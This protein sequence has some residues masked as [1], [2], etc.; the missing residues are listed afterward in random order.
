MAPR[1]SIGTPEWRPIVSDCLAP[2]HATRLPHTAASILERVSSIGTDGHDGGRPPLWRRRRYAL[3]AAAVAGLAGIAVGT[4][5]L[6]AGDSGANSGQGTAASGATVTVFNAEV[7][8]QHSSRD[9]C[10]LGLAGDP[11]APYAPANI[12]GHVH[13]GDRLRAECYVANA[14]NVTAEDH[15]ASRRWYRVQLDSREA[16]LPAVRLA[17]SAKPPVGTCSR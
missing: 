10:R 17:P 3:A 8:C 9:T 1:V 2:N 11:Y 16:W 15:R 7:A 6:T 5:A 4:V 14:R 12:V 13:H